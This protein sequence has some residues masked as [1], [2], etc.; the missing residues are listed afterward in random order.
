MEPNKA[1]GPDGFNPGFFQS[2]WPEIGSEIVRSCRMWLSE[3]ALPPFINRTNIILI[4]KIDNPV[5]MKDLRP[6]S[7]CSVIYRVIAKVL[8][9]RLRGVMPKLIST[10]QS[11]FIKGR[12]IVDNILVAFE[13]LHHMKRIQGAKEGE[14]AVKI[15]ISKAYDRVAWEYLK[16]VLIKVG[17]GQKWVDWMMMCVCSVEYTATVNSVKV[18]PIVPGRGL[19]QGCPLSP[20]LFL[21]CAEG[22]SNMLKKAERGGKLHGVRVCRGAPSVSHLLFADDSFFF[23]SANIAE[24]RELKRILLSYEA[25]SG[26]AINLT[27]SGA[28]FSANTHTM[29]RE[30][31]KAILG[32]YNPLDTGRYLGLPSMVGRR[33]KEVF[34]YIKNAIWNRMQGWKDRFI[35]QGGKEVLI[36]AVLQAIP[37]YS[38]NAFLLPKTMAEEIER[39]MNSFWWGT[40]DYGGG[41]V[42]WMRWERMCTLKEFGGLGFRNLMGFNLA[43]LG[44]QGWRFISDPNALV[45]RVFK[46]RYFPKGSFLSAEEGKNPSLVWKS[47]WSSQVVVEQGVRWKIGDGRNICVWTDPWIRDADFFQPRTDMVDGLEE[48]TIHGLMIPELREWDAELIETLFCSVD[49]GMILNMPLSSPG[50]RDAIL[51]HH[52]RDGNY[53]VRSAYRLAMEKVLNNTHLYVDGD[54]T[55]LWGIQAPP[56]VKHMIWRLGRE[57]LPT[58]ENLRRR[59]IVV[60][61][62]CGVCG[63]GNKIVRHLFVECPWVKDCWRITNMQWIVEAGI[64]THHSIRDWLLGIIQA[65]PMEV[66]QKVVMLMWA[67]WRERNDRVWNNKETTA[68]WVV[69]SALL[70][71]REWLDAKDG[72]R[73]PRRE[74]SDHCKM[75]HPP[76]EG[77][78]TCNVDAALFRTEVKSGVGMAIRDAHGALLHLRTNCWNGCW[79]STEVEGRALLEALS[80]AE[81]LGFSRLVFQSDAQQVVNDVNGRLELRTEFGDLTAGCNAILDRNPGSRCD[82]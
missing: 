81:E 79:S 65:N 72:M 70:E 17:F 77:V 9:N 26:Q 50:R 55:A 35:S 36:K 43:M 24:A 40:K 58:K 49:A 78:S 29:L 27:K 13:T 2:F 31:L 28:F 76:V 44:K 68:E 42:A 74:A 48:F 67:I 12:S 25:A 71:L 18:G 66:V 3:G 39:M 57:V 80:W 10:E 33:K 47:I 46:A 56:K 45:S 5:S 73:L 54:W 22:L 69:Q 53:T 19:R 64:D 14:M 82:S 16:A 23:C 20:F 21:L 34:A 1:P 6:I 15:D 4:P 61:V 30:G 38:M 37:T 32:I 59:H 60:S 75:W 41:G 62:G 51:W 63:Q 52:S 11:A 7:L 8:A